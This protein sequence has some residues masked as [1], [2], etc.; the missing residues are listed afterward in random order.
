VLLIAIQWSH[1]I[2]QNICRE[3]PNTMRA[4]VLNALTAGVSSFILLLTSVVL[5]TLVLVLFAYWYIE[6]APEVALWFK[7]LFGGILSE[8]GAAL[9]D[10]LDGIRQVDLF[11]H[12][13][14]ARPFVFYGSVAV[15]LFLGKFELAFIVAMAGA[16]IEGHNSSKP[17]PEQRASMLYFSSAG[18]FVLIVRAADSA[19]PI[20]TVFMFAVPFFL[21][22]STSK[23]VGMM[24]SQRGS[25]STYNAAANSA[26]AQSSR[27]WIRQAGMGGLALFLGATQGFPTAYLALMVAA[28]VEISNEQFDATLTFVTL[29]GACLVWSTGASWA[30]APWP[31]AMTAML[32]FNAGYAYRIGGSSSAH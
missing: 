23:L 7:R 6:G 15:L 4:H 30:H 29:G 8:V 14:D 26:D 2:Y 28:M 1:I 5:L 32:A 24:R 20:L 12:L 9:R 18:G 19:R 27:E 11:R 13:I 10:V 25:G 21:A 16:L 22:Q 3:E 17:A 31:A